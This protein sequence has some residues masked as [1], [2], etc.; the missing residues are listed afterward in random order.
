VDRLA[1]PVI[2][3][4]LGS[5]SILTQLAAAGLVDVLQVVVNPIALGAGKS[6]FHGLQAPLQ[7]RL[8]STRAFGNGAVVLS[9]AGGAESVDSTLVQARIEVTTR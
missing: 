4:E 5:G 8:T 9:Y 3:A 1:S 6:L 2:V 7:F